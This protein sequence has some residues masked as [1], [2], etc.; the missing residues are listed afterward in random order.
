MN[1]IDPNR[2]MSWLDDFE[3]STRLRNCF[4]HHTN[5]NS[6]QDVL[7]ASEMELLRIPNFGRR[8]LCEAREVFGPPLSPEP[9]PSGDREAE[10]RHEI[11]A[12]ATALWREHLIRRIEWLEHHLGR[13]KADIIESLTR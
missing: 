2:D 7:A 11:E 8:S 5:F 12:T 10:W 9:H 13:L 6:A 1:E 4:R 3:V